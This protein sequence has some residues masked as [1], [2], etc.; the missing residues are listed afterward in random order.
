MK[1]IAIVLLVFL[2]LAVGTSLCRA[3][4]RRCCPKKV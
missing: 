4:R 1:K 2:I 3:D